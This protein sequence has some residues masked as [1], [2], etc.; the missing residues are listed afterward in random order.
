MRLE[1]RSVYVSA[2]LPMIL[3]EN[4]RSGSAG[5]N[6]SA[7]TE[8]FGVTGAISQLRIAPSAP[9]I[10]VEQAMVDVTVQPC[11]RTCWGTNYALVAR[12]R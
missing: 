12:I 5:L 4:S 10:F 6:Q 7:M 3:R 1:R 8:V 2:S 11:R 9:R